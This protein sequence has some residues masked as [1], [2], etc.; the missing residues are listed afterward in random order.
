[1][2][3]DKTYFL[4]K[5]KSAIEIYA[6]LNILVG[7]LHH[8]TVLL[9][10][11]RDPR[12]K[13]GDETF[14]TLMQENL[15]E[16]SKKAMIKAED[17]STTAANA[18]GLFFDSPEE[19][20]YFKISEEIHLSQLEFDTTYTLFNLAE[21]LYLHKDKPENLAQEVETEYKARLGNYVKAIDSLVG[22][23]EAF[24]SYLKT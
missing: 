17:L 3:L 11:I 5:I 18:Y 8:S 24:S 20:R 10:T 14:K 13:Q 6:Q 22:K 16:H 21:E 1:M 23:F 19:E 2:D 9:K 4:S 7:A 12:Y 15:A